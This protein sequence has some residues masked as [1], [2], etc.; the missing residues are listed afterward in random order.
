MVD[1]FCVPDTAPSSTENP[2]NAFIRWQE[3]DL[4]LVCGDEVSAVMPGMMP[5]SSFRRFLILTVNGRIPVS[6]NDVYPLISL[7]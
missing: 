3:N 5:T 6:P 7:W 4:M 2:K 1:P